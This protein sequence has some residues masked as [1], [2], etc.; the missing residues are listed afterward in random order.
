MVNGETGKKLLSYNN[1]IKK[2][3]EAYQIKD[4]LKINHI[5]QNAINNKSINNTSVKMANKFL[6]Q[7]LGIALILFLTFYILKRWK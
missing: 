1:V 6:I 7:I 3:E 2:Y 4:L 5:E